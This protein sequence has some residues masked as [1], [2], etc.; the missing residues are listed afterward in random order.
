[1][2]RIRE[3]ESD[4]RMGYKPARVDVNAPLALIQVEGRA[5]AEALRWALGKRES[6]AGS[7]PSKKAAP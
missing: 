3:I 1:M 5:A 7:Y 4:E 2:Q 6:C